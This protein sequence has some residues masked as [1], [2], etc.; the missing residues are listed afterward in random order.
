M[1][2]IKGAGPY[3]DIVDAPSPDV[4][5]RKI[6]LGIRS[7]T[8]RQYAKRGLRSAIAQY[9]GIVQ[10]DLT[11]A[12]HIFRGLKRPLLHDGDMRADKTVLVYT[13]CSRR[14]YEWR[15]DPNYGGVVERTLPAGRAFVVLVR[16]RE[17]DEYGVSGSI[18]KWNWVEEDPE[19]PCAPV[20]WGQRYDTR[21]WSRGT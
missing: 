6:K 10:D 19:L 21:L 12:Q 9:Y 17:A 3:K 1:R 20:N 5:Q 11:I 16:S 4:Q 7:N 14:D 8:F 18:E 2:P 13:W 15:G